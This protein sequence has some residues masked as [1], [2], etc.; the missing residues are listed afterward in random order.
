MSASNEPEFSREQ[1]LEKPLPSSPESEKIIL[2]AILLDNSLMDNAAIR[3]VKE[4]FYSPL[5]ARVF[6]AMLALHTRMER[7]DPIL[8]GEEIKKD[9]S[10]DSIGG[11]ATI[12]NLSYG[13]PHFSD[14][15]DYIRVVKDKATLRNTIRACNKITT[16]C[17][18]EEREADAILEE[19]QDT[20]H[21]LT[22]GDILARAIV[23]AREAEA[24][25]QEMYTALDEGKIL[26]NPSGF[27]ELDAKLFGGGFWDGDLV[28]I[29][30]VT[31]GGKTTFALN[32]SSNAAELNIPN[33]Y[34]TMEM[35]RFKVFSRQHSAKSKIPGYKIRPHMT[36]LYGE[37][38]R[39]ELFETGYEMSQ[40][41]VGY[42]DSVRDMETIRRITK[43]A[44]RE[45]GVR[46]IEIDYFGLCKP[47]K[48]YR[49]TST[50]RAGLVAEL[51][52]ELAQEVSIP[53]IGLVQLRR[54]YKE[55]KQAGGDPEG[56]DIEPTLDMLK[57]SGDIENHADTV[58]FLWGE[59]GKEGEE[60]AIR[61]IHGR[62][63][64]QRNGVLF[65]FE[66]K[67][68]PAIYTFSSIGQLAALREKMAEEESK[69]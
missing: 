63:A 14:V 56:N 54:K 23:W 66:L 39:K 2:G 69:F 19:A 21:A 35:A 26:T 62:V 51:A 65:P 60:D 40:M 44:V 12:T 36:K 32:L 10:L 17:L 33:L 1:Y 34:F 53:V 61:D 59:K 46:Q 38:I 11:I 15:G 45:F 25:A 30:G 20:F 3:L 50:E 41:P 57:N 22:K 47:N 42:V 4:D 49:G 6:K 13:L 55:E 18:T 24:E 64:K 52:K 9:G 7:I 68:A 43:F 27:P 67:F 16:D 29:S 58:I 48:G 5:H 8:I 31:S 37:H 28:V